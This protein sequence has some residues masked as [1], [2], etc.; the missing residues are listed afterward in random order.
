[1]DQSHSGIFISK[2]IREARDEML[3]E[4]E[5]MRAAS[6]KPIPSEE[7]FTSVAVRE[8][9]DEILRETKWMRR[10]ASKAFPTARS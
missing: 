2:A 1:M 10:A 7:L 5:W 3:K 4:T 6:L 8:A 9:R